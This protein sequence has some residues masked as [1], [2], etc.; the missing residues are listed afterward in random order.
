MA[1]FDL[2]ADAFV[3][4]LGHNRAAIEAVFQ[5]V[6]AQILDYLAGAGSH[7]PLPSV[8]RVPF[9]GIP[10]QS[11]AIASLLESLDDL[12]AQSMNPAHP[13]Y[14]G[15]MDPL[16]STASIVGD[17]VAAALN[18]NMLS[19]EM[20]PVLSRL[21]PL[22]LAEIA[23]LF[24]LGE[25]AG[26]LLTSGG[27]LANLQALTLARN[28]K[29]DCLYGG[30]ANG[31][32]PVILAS[33]LA[34]TSIQKAAMVLG[35]GIDGV[36]LVP[37]DAH[38]QMD[39]AALEHK[40]QAAIALG[41][42]PFAV[43]ATAGTTVTGNIDPLPAI[44]RIAKAYG[45][46]FHVDAAYGGAIAFSPTHRHRLAGIEQA[47]SITFNP[48]KWLYVT[49][50]CASVLFRDLG[51]LHSHFRVSAPYMNTEVDWAN[52]GE[53]SVQGTRHTDVLKLWLTL[54]HLGKA[55]CAELIDASYALTRHFVAQVRLR[56][57]LKL[58]SN[59]DMNLVCFRGCPPELSPE[60]WD[61]WNRGLQQHLLNQHRTFLS[62]PVLRGQRWLKAVLLNPFTTAAQV[63]DLFL[64]IDGYRGKVQ[65]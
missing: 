51:L 24:G 52:L 10:E 2:P 29:L 47:D 40:I 22:L 23:Q 25:A 33:E 62:L 59:P 28:V 49:K 34:H 38:A 45:L 8:E 20:S 27:S 7:G 56:P 18:N 46:W 9:K 17:W 21:E 50:T 39:I 54:A 48:Q 35:L 64:A 31:L 12:M 5:Q 44:A 11:T 41:Q 61:S 65:P 60:Q 4:P 16:P 19:V 43:V 36:A 32:P 55:G 53:L 42:R 15:H 14:L 1:F 6:V 57:Y 13:G 30:L 26:G 3:H 63:S 58:A 37:T